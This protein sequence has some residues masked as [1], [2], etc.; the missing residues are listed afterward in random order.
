MTQ[1]HFQLLHPRLAKIERAKQ[2]EMDQK[3]ATPV[4]RQL[5][6]RLGTNP[7]RSAARFTPPR[8]TVAVLVYA[9]NQAGYFPHRLDVTRLT[10]ESIL[11]NTPEPF[12]HWFLIMAPA[13]R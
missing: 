3:L 11:A 12:E 8:V 6:A 13:R 10:I 5:I 1:K 2:A 7:P 4:R 9:P